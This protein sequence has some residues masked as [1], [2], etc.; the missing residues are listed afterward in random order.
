M[1]SP[2]R[3]AI[4]RLAHIPS[5]W[6]ER[7]FMDGR[8]SYLDLKAELVPDWA[9]SVQATLYRKDGRV[10]LYICAWPKSLRGWPTEE[11]GKDIRAL[12][13]VQLQRGSTGAHFAAFGPTQQEVDAIIDDPEIAIAHSAALDAPRDSR[14][15]FDAVAHLR[16]LQQQRV[17]RLRALYPEAP[18]LNLKRVQEL[19]QEIDELLGKIEKD[20]RSTR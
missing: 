10:G 11:A 7:T 13:R 1:T 5:V 4:E 16:A 20:E 12:F 15:Y 8:E 6:S 2:L 18:P 14:E 19:Q 17:D 3:A 9:E